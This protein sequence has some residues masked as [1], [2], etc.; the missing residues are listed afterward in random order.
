MWI[1]IISPPPPVT[2]THPHTSEP[3]SQVTTAST[4]L[5]ITLNA[6]QQDKSKEY[7]TFLREKP[8]FPLYFPVVL[9][10]RA[11]VRVSVQWSLN[12]WPWPRNKEV[13]LKESIN[14]Q[15]NGK[16]IYYEVLESLLL[17]SFHL[18]TKNADSKK[19]RND[20]RGNTR[21]KNPL[22]DNIF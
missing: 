21:E 22:K 10:F 16:H 7:H 5:S 4:A 2:H 12:P 13:M 17:A 20:T 3:H 9:I 15:K 14:K 6:R 1:A 18:M 19:Q 8:W 11:I